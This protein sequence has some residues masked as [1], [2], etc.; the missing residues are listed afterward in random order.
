MKETPG[1]NVQLDLFLP[2]PIGVMSLKVIALMIVKTS[3][4]MA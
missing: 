1:E 3:T 2:L 4:P